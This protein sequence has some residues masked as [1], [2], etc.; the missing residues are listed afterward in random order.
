MLEVK[1]MNL[2]HRVH[3]L[4]KEERGGYG[5]KLFKTY[6]HIYDRNMCKVG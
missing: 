3:L 1:K 5:N 6:T 2:Q 4:K